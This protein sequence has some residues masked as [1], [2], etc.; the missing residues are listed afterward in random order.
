MSTDSSLAYFVRI[1]Y[2]TGYQ[3]YLIW[4]R[5]ALS[6]P[7]GV[8]QAY[9]EETARYLFGDINPNFKST[10]LDSQVRSPH[11]SPNTILV[12]IF[13]R[14]RRDMLVRTLGDDNVNQ[15]GPRSTGCTPRPTRAGY[16][17]R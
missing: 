12:I 3:G 10:L 9:A 7:S 6:C 17:Q 16:E 4:P 1:Q 5:L 11:R 14:P 13:V 8:P 15:V 2:N